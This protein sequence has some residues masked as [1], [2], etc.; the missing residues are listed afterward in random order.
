MPDTHADSRFADNAFVRGKPFLRF[1]AG[2]PIKVS[3]ET[4]GTLCVMDTKPRDFSEEAVATLKDLAAIAV[5]ELL[6]R[7]LSMVDGLTGAMS[8]R[9]FR[10]EGERMFNL[11]NRHGHR[12]TCA[13]FDIDHFKSVNDR[14]GHAIGDAVLSAVVATCRGNLRGS[15]VIGRIGGEE[16]G[17]LLPHTDLANGIAVLEKARAAIGAAVINTPSGPIRVTASFGGA[18][19]LPGHRFDDTLHNADLAMYSA[20]EAGRNKVNAWIDPL[21]SAAPGKRRVLKAGQI[22]FN[23]GRSTIDCT[24]RGLSSDMAMIDVI[25]TANVPGEFKLS[26]ASDGFSRACRVVT[27]SNNKL[28]VAFS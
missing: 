26:I 1:Y 19:F 3:G 8:R 6:L 25:S 20:K 17:I 11:A 7:N 18:S 24:I 22:T 4:V 27:K 13:V 12:L 2:A 28:E 14:N 23:S 16:F 10:A 15:D 5:D 21:P 9:A